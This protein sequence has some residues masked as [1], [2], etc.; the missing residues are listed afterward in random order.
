MGKNKRG[1]PPTGESYKYALLDMKRSNLLIST[2]WAGKDQEERW[3]ALKRD[4][5][6][7]EAW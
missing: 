3:P 4:K 5:D 1:G 2:F 6:R 7:F